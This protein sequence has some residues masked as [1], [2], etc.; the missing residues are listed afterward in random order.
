MTVLRGFSGSY[1][2]FFFVVRS[3]EL[4]AFVQQAQTIQSAE[5]FQ[6]FVGRFGVRR[7]S[8]DFWKQADWF[9]ESYNAAKPIEAGIFDLNRYE[10]R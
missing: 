3:D 9:Q 6:L 1:P 7:T 4:A 2:R 5:D 8:T 10:N